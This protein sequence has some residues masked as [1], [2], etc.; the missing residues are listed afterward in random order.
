MKQATIEA[1]LSAGYRKDQVMEV[2]LGVALKTIS[3]YL[4]PWSRTP[5]DQPFDAEKFVE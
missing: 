5:L 2:L 4:D 1:F 3:N